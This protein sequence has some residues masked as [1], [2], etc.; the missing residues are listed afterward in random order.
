MVL[1]RIF[2]RTK[3]VAVR[4][5]SIPAGQRFYAVGDIHGRLDL[6]DALIAQIDADHAARGPAEV[7]LVFLGDLVDRGPQSRGV[8]ERVMEL[9]TKRANTRCLGGNHEDILL[10]CLEGDKRTLSTFHRVGGRETL[11]SYGVS[12]DDYDAASLDEIS[13]LA[14][15][16]VPKD[17]IAFLSGLGDY[18]LAG[19][20][21][22]VHAGIMPGMPLADQS[23]EAMR[24]IRGEF[25]ECPDDFGVMVI[26]GH[27][28]TEAVDARTNRI[29]IDTGAYATGRLTAI[30]L[31]A[32]ERWFLSTQGAAG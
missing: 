22:F 27:T 11:I 24:W 20:Y 15:D 13:L 12:A 21:L 31:E 28:I 10:R 5:F 29:G 23:R 8:V 4:E 16:A 9:C 6:L 18:L 7:H 1:K 32:T 26:H 14:Q 30:G 3:S 17:H 25:T 19:S 2:G